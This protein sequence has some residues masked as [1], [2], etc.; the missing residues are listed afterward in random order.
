MQIIVENIKVR[1]FLCDAIYN[2]S[3]FL[4]KENFNA[5]WSKQ[6]LNSLKMAYK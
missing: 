3:K 6:W 1:P 2:E 5:D 4:R